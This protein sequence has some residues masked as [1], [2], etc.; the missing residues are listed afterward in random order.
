MRARRRVPY[1]PWGDSLAPVCRPSARHVGRP[2]WWTACLWVV[3]DARL[4]T[5]PCDMALVLGAGP[6]A[7]ARHD[8]GSCIRHRSLEV[9]WDEYA[10]SERLGTAPAAM[11]TRSSRPRLR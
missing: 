1:P 7:R 3:G 9:I 5:P 8:A 11:T 4:A 10:L 6:G 2:H